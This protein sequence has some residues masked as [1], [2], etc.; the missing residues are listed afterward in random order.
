MAHGEEGE[1]DRDGDKNLVRF[2]DDAQQ[3]QRSGEASQPGGKRG[4]FG[5]DGGREDVRHD[6]EDEEVVTLAEVSCGHDCEC[7]DED[8]GEA[9]EGGRGEFEV[10]PA[11]ETQAE[12]SDAEFK[13]CDKEFAEGG[14]REVRD[15]G[16]C[17]RKHRKPD[18]ERGVGLEDLGAVERCAMEDEAR[19]VEEPHL[20]VAGGREQGE[21]ASHAAGADK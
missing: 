13:G 9:V 16:E 14:I 12:C 4:A 8:E 21:E 15:V 19:G 3:C 20:V 6:E 18:D 11:E 7:G 1:L 2:E 5:A 10:R 17:L